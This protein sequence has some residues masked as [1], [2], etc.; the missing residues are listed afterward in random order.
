MKNY[1]KFKNDSEERMYLFATLMSLRPSYQKLKDKERIV[2]MSGGREHRLSDESF[3]ELLY[4]TAI[5]GFGGERACYDKLPR[6]FK[7]PPN[8]EVY[9]TDGDFRFFE[10]CE[11]YNENKVRAKEL[12]IE[13]MY[14]KEKDDFILINDETVEVKTPNHKGILLT[15]SQFRTAQKAD[16]IYIIDRG[17]PLGFYRSSEIIPPDFNLDYFKE[18]KNK[19][20]NKGK[21]SLPLSNFSNIPGLSHEEIDK[22]IDM[23]YTKTGQSRMRLV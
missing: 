7:N 18:P 15:E 20:R 14:Y 13:L 17:T 12:G 19:V 9:C 16:W 3:F 5:L 23:E 2:K 11:F 10:T 22:L 8:H 6:L 1:R 4:S 21:L